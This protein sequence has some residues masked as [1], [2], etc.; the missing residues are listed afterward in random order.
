MSKFLKGLLV[1]L[2][3]MAF[4]ISCTTK[5]NNKPTITVSIAP[6]RFFVER[7]AGKGY[8]VNVLVPKDANPEMYDPTPRDIAAIAHSDVY[9][10]MGSLAFEHVWLQ[11]IKEQNAD[12]TCVDISKYLPPMKHV[13]VH[14]DGHVHGDPHFWSSIMGAKAISRGIYEKLIEMYP[15][16]TQLFESNYNEL[17]TEIEALEAECQAVFENVKQRVFIIYHPSLSYFADEWHLEQRAIEKDGKEPTPAHLAELI[18]KAKADDVRLVFI[19]EEFDIKNAEIVAREIGAKTVTIRPLDE[20]W[21]GQ[22]R[23]LISAFASL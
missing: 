15:H 20:D 10:Y 23:L 12:I 18:A 17:L 2:P 4:L 22:I 8:E 7:I 1:F 16:D 6:E 13:C 21:V 14:K 9:F 11:A 3:V 5:H 19:Q